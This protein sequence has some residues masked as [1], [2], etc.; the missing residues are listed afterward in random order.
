MLHSIGPG[1]SPLPR[2]ARIRLQGLR[3]ACLILTALLAGA[4]A[5][6]RPA[7]SA[8]LAAHRA[9]ELLVKFRAGATP[10]DAE[11]ILRDLGATRLRRFHRIHA[12]KVRISRLTVEEAIA[13]YG[14][15]PAV[16]FIEPNYLVH[17]E[18]TIP[19]DPL[20]NQQWA[21]RN[22]GQDGGTPG[23]DIDATRAWDATT[24]AGDVIVAIIDTGV[25]YTHADLVDNM[26]RNEGEIPSNGLD[27]DGNGYVDD[28]FG[29]DFVNLDPDPF[30][31]HGHGT[32]VAGIVGAVGNNAAGVA[33]VAWH[34][35]LLPLKFLGRS[36]GGY[37]DDAVSAIEYALDKGARVL[38]A[39]WGG[40][41]YSQALRDAIADADAADVTFV[42]ASGNEGRDSDLTP[43]YP[44]NFDVPN[45]VS[46]AASTAGDG[47]ADF[48]NY[49]V[50]T[51]DLAAP[52]V[53]I[54]STIPNGL[55]GYNSGTSMAAPFISGA[56]ALLLGRFPAMSH[57]TARTVLFASADPV[58][59]LTGFVATGARLNVARMLEG[60]D[61][62]APGPVDD[63]AVATIG[64]NR[65]TLRFTAPGDDGAVGTA[66]RYDLR[67]GTAPFDPS[68]F[69]QA[70][71]A[72]GIPPPVP[73]GTTQEIVV[74]GLATRTLYYFALRA[75][76]EYGNAGPI[77]NLA[78]GTTFGPPVLATT[79]E[80]L[81]ASLLT[82]GRSAQALRLS[83]AGEGTLDF[84]VVPEE[85]P[86]P[87]AVHAYA[88]L[89]KDQP[90][91][92]T[93]DPVSAGVGGPDRF[94]YRWIDSDEPAGP[95]FEWVDVSGTGEA[96][97]LSGDD[98]TSDPL[99]IGFSFPF[100]GTGFTQVRVCTNG[101]LS[102]TSASNE[103]TNQ[104]LPNTGAPE[105]LVAPF[106]DD[107][108]V[109]PSSSRI[110]RHFDGARLIVQF[111]E[112]QHI[113]GSGPY[114]F[115]VI[116]YPTG[117]IR[118]QYL[119]V[120]NP[121][122]SATVGIQNGARDD[123]ITIAFNT[124]YVRPG[125]AA[126]IAPAPRW[127]AARPEQGTVPA[128][129]GLD[130]EVA[131]NASGL[132]SGSYFA[133]L[134][135]RSNDPGR[136]EAVIP[137][138]LHVTGA[139]DASVAPS[140]LDFDTVFVGT[141]RALDLV[142]SNFGSEPLEVIPAPLAVG[143]FRADPSPF[144]LPP[145]DSRTIP[146]RYEPAAA[147]S[148]TATLVLAT[149]DPD[150]PEIRIPLRGA[151]LPPPDI[152]VA[153]PS[154][155]EALRSG[156]T[157]LR[158]L[159]IENVGESDLTFRI[160]ATEGLAGSG[161][162]GSAPVASGGPAPASDDPASWAGYRDAGPAPKRI[163]GMTGIAPGAS[164]P[165]IVVD[166]PDDGGPVD[167]VSLRASAASGVLFVEMAFATVINPLQFGGFF[168]LDVDQDPSTG[169]PP[170]FGNGRQVLGVEYEFQ[171]F[172]LQAGYVRLVDRRTGAVVGNFAATSDPHTVRFSAPLSALGN[173]DGQMDCA[174]VVGNGTSPT[175]WFPDEG[176][177]I[178]GSI[179]WL[180]VRPSEGRVPPGGQAGIALTM[181]AAGLLEGDYA[182]RLRIDS[183]DPD[184]PATVVPL[185]LHV[186]GIPD[187][188]VS[189]D[190][191]DF[192]VAFIGTVVTRVLR[193]TNAG[194]GTLHVSAATLDDPISYI[195][196]LSE[197]TL[198]PGERTNL[199]VQF[200][201]IT[202]GEAPGELHFISDDP[203]EG[204]RIVV[205]RGAGILPPDIVVE[206]DSLAADLLTG[207]AA[208]RTVTVRNE[209]A[210]DL[211]VRGATRRA[212]YTPAVTAPAFAPAAAG[213][214]RDTDSRPAPVRAAS[215]APGD[216][217]VLVI[218]DTVAWGL[219]LAGLI[220]EYFG[221]QP[222]VI[223][224]DRIGQ[225]D[226]A[227]YDVIITSGDEDDAY[228]AALSSHV[229]KFERFVE[230][231]G[232]VQYDAATQGA[233]VLLV[234]G[235][236][237]RYANQETRNRILLPNH[238]IAAGLPLDLEADLVN[239]CT[240]DSLPPDARIIT[241]TSLSRQPTTVEYR[242]GRGTVIATGM[243]WEFLALYA[244]PA[245]A[246]LTQSLVYALSLAHPHWLGIDP[247]SATIP[248]GGSA[249]FTVRFQADGL[250]GGDYGAFAE[251]SS[252]DP[253]EPVKL[254]VA[255][256]HV[257]GAPDLEVSR[258]SLAFDPTFV[259]AARSESLV[260]R[261][262]GSD[263]LRLDIR[264]VNGAFIVDAFSGELGP[265]AEY[266]VR[267]VFAPHSTGSFSDT[268]R[269][270][271]ND[272]DRP[273][274][275]VPLG[276][277]GMAPP[278]AVVAPDSLAA[279]L[280]T[281]G[282]D[283]RT[284]T[285]G[286]VG[287]SDLAISVFGRRRSPG[288][289][290]TSAET[291][292]GPAV[293]VIQDTPAW[294]IDLG[295]LLREALGLDPRVIRTAQIDAVDLGAY[296]LIVTAGA[297]DVGYYYAIRTRAD[298]FAAFARAGG[299]VQYQLATY[300]SEVDVAGGARVVH[301]GA[302]DRNLVVAPGHPITA[303]L[304]DTLSGDG[305]N[306]GTIQDLPP[307]AR[308]ITVAAESGAPTT[309]EYPVG[310]GRVL[311]TA[312]PWER[313]H[314]GASAAAPLLLAATRYSITWAYPSWLAVSPAQAVVPPGASVAVSVALDARGLEGGF[315]TADVV[316][317][318][319]D[320][321]APSTSIPLT[322]DVTGVAALDASP[323]SLE[324]DSVYVGQ[325]RARL[326]TLRNVGSGPLRVSRLV[327]GNAAYRVSASELALPAHTRSTVTVTFEPGTAGPAPAAL[328]IDHD[329]PL[330]PRSIA[331]AGVGVPPPIVAPDPS[332]VTSELPTG[333]EE[334]RT[335]LIRNEGGS[336]L[337][338]TAEALNG[339]PAV[340]AH[341]ALALG[342]GEPDP[343][344]GQAFGAGR[345]GPDRYGYYWTDSDDPQGPGFSWIDI[346]P[347][348]IPIAI[349][350]DDQTSLPQSIGFEF[351]FYGARFTELRVCT[352]GWI[353]F[354][355]SG[356][357]FV[358]QPLPSPGAPGNLLAPFWDDLFFNAGSSVA[359]FYDG[360]KLIVQFSAVG[361]YGI[362]GPF[363]FQVLLYPTGAIV[364]QYFSMG[365]PLDSATIGLQNEDGT[366][367]LTVAFNA[368]YLHDRMAIRFSPAPE[369]LTVD[370]SAGIVPA[371]QSRPVSLLFR[372]GGL[373][374]G[375]YDARLR[376]RSN[377]PTT[378]LL[379]VP[380]RLHVRGV[381]RLAVTPAAL[382]FDTVFVGS[383][384][385]RALT[386][387]NT[388]TDLL[389]LGPA[390]ASSPEFQAVA[391]TLA[392]APLESGALAVS[393][394]PAGAG[395][396]SALL[397][398][399]SNDPDGP[400][401]VPLTAIALLP[402]EASLL[403]ARI[404]AAAPPG[405]RALKS[406]TLENRG[407]SDLRFE[408]RSPALGGSGYAWRDGD[409]A[410]GPAFAWIDIRAAGVRVPLEALENDRTV[411]P[412]PIGFTFPFY[413]RAFG[414]FHVCTNGWI[415]LTSGDV[416]GEDGPLPSA[417]APENLIAVLWDDL[418]CDAGIG[419]GIWYGLDGGRLVVQFENL[420]RAADPGGG[421]CSFEV[422]LNPG[423]GIL[424][425]YRALSGSAES[426]TVGI[427]N[428]LRDEGL[429]LVSGGPYLREGLAVRLTP[430]PPWITVTPGSGVLRP[431]ERAALALALDASG[432]EDGDH[433]ARLRFATN[434]P[435]RPVIGSDLLLHV[436]LRE[437]VDA[438]FNPRT[439]NLE[440]NGRTVRA[441]V[442]LPPDL[443]PRE[444]VL[445]SVRL[446]DTVPALADSLR[447]QDL[448]RNGVPDLDLRF[449]RD[450]A[451]AVLS[452]GDLVPVRIVGE[453]RDR[454]W[455]VAR[456]T[457]RAI[458]PHVVAPG[459]E[460]AETDLPVRFALHANAPNPF[461]PS[462]TIG[463]D[464]PRPSRVRL[465]IFDARGR[466]VRVLVDGNLPA[467]RHR[468]HWDGRMERGGAAASGVYFARFRA[469]SFAASR[470]ML[471]LR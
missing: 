183:N 301:G 136:P 318:T 29:Y 187:I 14:E 229:G 340:T 124:G 186:Q 393:F 468:A 146:V 81:S 450:A 95:G 76:D 220:I 20:F 343:R 252:N 96:I 141:E 58:P 310:L 145:A 256:L 80:S 348:G 460:S 444:V 49:G 448:N 89:A 433:A 361:R 103:Y 347:L 429:T 316:V 441:R 151:G 465:A 117:E 275:A 100:Y 291:A 99:P 199:R 82:G 42:A 365:Q 417:K 353:S 396:R 223:P 213:A 282:T 191:L 190:T 294:G 238:P 182:G 342:K 285:V 125:L 333:G 5:W 232:I 116:L 11:A 457:V 387:T 391:G 438:D 373:F 169:A 66:S 200:L 323:A 13:R 367:G 390:V 296:D 105:N 312:M 295:L 349:R 111:Q 120:A 281:G 424:L 430:P 77:S 224:S 410:D 83:N 166:P 222:T 461:R 240:I 263:P 3:T 331:L 15:D 88:A 149:N 327:V 309:A 262:T 372:A 54:L 211:R 371:G 344:P 195:L 148:D 431:G 251:F 423:G 67:Y 335:L 138:A 397:S 283:R 202:E 227:A 37:V 404:E 380:V 236:Q 246:M 56:L 43:H 123:G 150:E 51:V 362:G 226:F 377:D 363:T 139:P 90:D 364:Y 44:S 159:R 277:E 119:E 414:S 394:T 154:Y 163:L 376:V 185:S 384:A 330:G 329:A 86:V 28:V 175:D 144:S 79:P 201:S 59:A 214:T 470:R 97:A 253:D 93:G 107:L 250:N 406:L 34:V 57:A 398:I 352:N 284:V 131:F 194:T 324:F 306:N 219:D 409:A 27:D 314:P 416:S 142:V 71:P 432:L 279:A 345:G 50:T 140:A 19:D 241:E 395:S 449:D 9:G 290:S 464:L 65:I 403:P 271:S 110:Y 358:N 313:L 428:D 18:E 346:R 249:P 300:G 188:R 104:I 378:S 466:L 458:R 421:P 75:V 21:L 418:R 383:T 31:D 156:E 386:V 459:V 389:A 178:I 192:G 133:D 412:L 272:P 368:A 53:G 356:V 210:S 298:R 153:P 113:G 174:G 68:T 22:F 321:Q 168:S 216:P 177:G 12:D 33:G 102:F 337:R 193:V 228:Y 108:Y 385:E 161:T 52:G 257:T 72:I 217:A 62:V 162:G 270:G 286:N 23:A 437:A 165:V 109:D 254:V 60:F 269:I 206:P 454:T 7:A 179:P 55:Y 379:D 422:I 135:I 36:G 248:P 311:V 118:F 209:G 48:S 92:R 152:V 259:G 122:T 425:Q 237:A 266:V 47:L 278:R 85:S 221:I 326:L 302:E 452:E 462:T 155:D 280:P 305:L 382:D 264:G 265:G 74:G 442:E 375:E 427:Q 207:Q 94:G 317:E 10:Q 45:I 132:L 4:P 401:R 134:R 357:D 276:G 415:S 112:V 121:A 231:G 171:L 70:A 336:D 325:S 439:L 355:A 69:P 8:T 287:E 469:G 260:V 351:P 181:N 455:F 244:L 332:A 388:G 212:A 370:P 46:V 339:A 235:A 205:L 328:A 366:D 137:A 303:E 359:R 360:T 413:G 196:D 64:S 392:L 426:A 234:G 160:T 40:G 447:V 245:G 197:F 255:S 267:V 261:S 198:T 440:S 218:E 315:H 258:S 307:D 405:G 184:H 435:A 297:Q 16:E 420:T 35:R 408:A 274:V 293:L 288:A 30:D 26:W 24:S 126:R 299:V 419:A 242:H 320:P 180:S 158:T 247:A 239:H 157:A 84:A 128:G 434:D 38:N 443:D 453:V 114:S 91:D 208:G 369:W 6:T 129:E 189:A 233:D 451:A 273:D 399:E 322:L 39:S 467:G 167:L 173:D 304:P 456:D 130:L 350:D 381:P 289:A 61:A 225:T 308:I 203:D 319:N 436:G 445:A 78:S 2:P 334:S 63:L 471:R 374:P 204:D 463:F 147:G 32:H 407:G 41:P 176:H 87:V 17:V 230:D 215:V 143:P 268:L 164:L 101:F 1:G 98:A 292:G 402:P 411:G 106:W 115:E 400:A 341:A 73:A 446:M 127:L 338:F 354:T 172:T 25:D 243:T 170:S